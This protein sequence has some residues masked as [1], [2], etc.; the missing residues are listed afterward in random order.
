LIFG[1][2]HAVDHNAVM[3]LFTPGL[4][5]LAISTGAIG[6]FPKI[7]HLTEK[8]IIALTGCPVFIQSILGILFNPNCGA[9]F[10]GFMV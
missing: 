10:A 6:L 9:R 3:I 4:E 8:A 5:F 2:N 7:N 1:Q